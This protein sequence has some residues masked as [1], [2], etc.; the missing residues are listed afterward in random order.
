MLLILKPSL[1]SATPLI[2]W[3]ILGNTFLYNVE[4]LDKTMTQTTW[5]KFSIKE[6]NILLEKWHS[7]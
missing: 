2:I 3:L 7:G 6:R 5:V 1:L 4:N